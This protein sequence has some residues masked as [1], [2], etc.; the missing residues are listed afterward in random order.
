MLTDRRPIAQQWQRR[1]RQQNQEGSGPTNEGERNRRN[2]PDDKAAEHGI[3]GPEQ[4]GQ[5]QQEIR[6]IEQ[7]TTRAALVTNARSRHDSNPQL[8]R[9]ELSRTAPDDQCPDGMTGPSSGCRDN[10]SPPRF[11]PKH[12]SAS[13]GLLNLLGIQ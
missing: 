4:R 3:P 13:W 9:Y 2:V 12:G 6:L 10:R 11:T 5:R 1:E 8:I 7:P